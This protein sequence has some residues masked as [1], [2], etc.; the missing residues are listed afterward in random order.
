MNEVEK[1]RAGPP[2]RLRSLSRAGHI[3][4]KL[5]KL[6]PTA[7]MILEYSNDWEL[8]VS[9]MLSAQCTDK[10]VN[11]VTKTLFKKYKTLDDYANAKLSVLE[12]DVLPT[13]FYKQKAKRIKESARIVRDTFDG[14]VPH[15]MSDMLT[16]PGVA[17]KTAN[18]VLGN[19][20]GVVEGIA[21]D[22]HVKRIAY[23]FGLTKNTDPIKIEQDLMKLFPKKQ[24]FHLTYL[25]IDFGRAYCPARKHDHDRCEKLAG[26]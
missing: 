4:K 21:V 3:Y 25:L 14:E 24:W 20:Y 6:F 7:G 2:E 11:K 17:R 26:L 23:K 15:T 19:A 1:K 13:G 22:T 9:V 18:V 12:K 8:L 16:L 10:Q 5:Q